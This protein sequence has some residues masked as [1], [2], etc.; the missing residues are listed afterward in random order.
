MNDDMRLFKDDIECPNSGFDIY[1]R[2][3][4]CREDIAKHNK[5]AT[6]RVYQ[7]KWHT[8]SKKKKTKL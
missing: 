7:A 3:L 1:C 6:N 8:L 5:P 4:Q 2:E